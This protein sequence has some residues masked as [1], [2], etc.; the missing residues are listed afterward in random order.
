MLP[1]LNDIQN[2]IETGMVLSPDHIELLDHDAIL[3]ARDGKAFEDSWLQAER[4]Q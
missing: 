2:A 1:S 3:D 4:G